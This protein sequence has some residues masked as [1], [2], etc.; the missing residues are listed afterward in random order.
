M[1]QVLTNCVDVH[2]E[3]WQYKV[4]S[5]EIYR[6]TLEEIGLF[7]KK[8]LSSLAGIA[9]ALGVVAGASAKSPVTTLAFN[10]LGTSAAPA[11]KLAAPAAVPGHIAVAKTRKVSDGTVIGGLGV[12]AITAGVVI[13]T[14]DGDSTS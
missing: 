12:L 10:D 7:M 5:E 13:A 6:I 11:A 1:L 2:G 9:L 8:V 4:L 14:E 3:P